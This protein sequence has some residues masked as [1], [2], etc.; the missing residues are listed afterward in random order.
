MYKLYRYYNIVPTYLTKI[1]K[2]IEA[3]FSTLDS[4]L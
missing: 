2:E 4:A 3:I 1:F